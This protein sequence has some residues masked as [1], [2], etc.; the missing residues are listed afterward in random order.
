MAWGDK[1]ERQAR[2]ARR[3]TRRRRVVTLH[4]RLWADKE[5]KAT[6]TREAAEVEYDYAR[7]H[8]AKERDPARR[9][10]LYRDLHDTLTQFNVKHGWRTK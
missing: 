8:I 7:A 9:E 4:D 5:A 10:A 6:T 1:G 2:K 3:A